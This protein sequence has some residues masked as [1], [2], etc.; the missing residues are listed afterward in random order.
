MASRVRRL[1]I[2]RGFGAL[3][4]LALVAH[5]AH[6]ELGLGGHTLDGFFDDWV[7]DA[8]IMGGALSCLIRAW[9][10]REER[11]AW[12]LLGLGLASDASGEIYYSL[13]FGE[14][15]TPPI[16]SLADLLYLLYYPAAYAGMVLLV[17]ERLHRF[18]TSMWLDGAIAATT[19][20][21][22]IAAVA[23]EPIVR[24]AGHQQPAA[25]A[26]TLAYPLGDLI[27]L[28]IAIGV[29]GLAGWRPG[30][31]WLLLALGLGLSAVADTSYLYANA[32]GTYTVGGWLDSIWVASA[33]AIGSAAWQSR[34]APR[35]LRLEGIRVLLIPG[36]F[37]LGAL[38]ILLYGGFRHVGAVGLVLAATAILLVILRAGWTFRD[39]LDLL[40]ASRREAVT[41][42]L[43]G[44]GNRR[45]LTG[46]LERALGERAGA[47]ECVLV[48]FDLDGFKL[49]NDTFGHM[50]GDTLLSHL[51]RCLQLA[52]EAAGT[53]YRLGGDEFCVLLQRD[54]ERAD[55]YVGAAAEALIA[56]GEGFKVGASYGRVTI[57]READTPG[58]A[59]RLADDRMYAHKGGRAGSARSQTQNV[60]LELLHERQPELAEHL[61][62]VAS[63]ALTVGRQ[64]ALGPD[65]LDELRRA[66]ELH[67]IGKAAIPD[68]IL[69]K[70]GP[71]D[72]HESWFMRRHTIVGERILAAAPALAPV[73]PLVRSSHERWDGGGY[74]DG[75]AGVEIPLGARIIAVCDAFDAITSERPYAPSRSP[76]QA[77]EELRRGAG[78]HFDPTV[79]DAFAA[80]YREQLD[81]LLTTPQAAGVVEA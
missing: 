42:A 38:A 9:R 24:G 27:L 43:T 74:P 22:I 59:L 19:S 29:F 7:Y 67:D 34:S 79:V 54:L 17:R 60:L 58:Y 6:G 49:Y 69:G 47:A 57:P 23:F 40:A 25:L 70:T 51:G 50:A 10:V 48:M 66:A 73:A 77:I 44:L 56:E 18:S 32:N 1:P 76:E 11:F 5:V 28:G 15:A 46:D 12:L 31:A 13:A 39:N 78:S 30:R 14:S 61:H 80:A 71:L 53:A 62:A 20:S 21:A 55:S 75:L 68:A 33:L 63:L 16:P 72:E 41:D 35:A 4:V 26:T 81:E 65:E 36:A 37:A 3:G 52:V 8:A 2:A 64:L 45:A